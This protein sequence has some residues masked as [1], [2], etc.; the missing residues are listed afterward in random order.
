MEQEDLQ[1]EL[2]RQVSANPS[3][4]V[5]VS[6]APPFGLLDEARPGEHIGH[7]PL[8]EFLRSPSGASVALAL[9]GHVHE[10]FG[11]GVIGGARVY[12]VAC[13]Y[14]LL[15]Q[16]EQGWKTLHLQRFEQFAGNRE[17]RP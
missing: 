7:R 8:A 3:P 13:G 16:V 4:H 17:E 14:A 6:H 1:A 9:C 10:G 2:D 15:E 11:Q 5:V 12:N